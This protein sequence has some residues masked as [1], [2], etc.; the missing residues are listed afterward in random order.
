M[1]VVFT[2]F[3]R[4]EIVY[5]LYFIKKNL[6]LYLLEYYYIFYTNIV[7][8]IVWIYNYLCNQCLSPLMLWVWI[9]HRWSVL[10]TTLCNKVCQWRVTG[11]WFSSCTPVSC[12]NKTDRHDI[13]QTY[14][15]VVLNTI[16]PI[17]ISIHKSMIYN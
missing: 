7:A 14:L 5:I 2:S 11:R 12:T 4:I 8:V 1:G 6:H 15:K 10:D 13:A 16:T 9:L 3:S 17:Q